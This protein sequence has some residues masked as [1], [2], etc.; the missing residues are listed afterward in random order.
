[1]KISNLLLGVICLIHAVEDFVSDGGRK[2]LVEGWPQIR[3]SIICFLEIKVNLVFF[4]F[5]LSLYL[6][7]VL[8]FQK[9]Y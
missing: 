1:M 4:F 2:G 3:Q 8:V 5:L 7:Y 9:H 6:Y